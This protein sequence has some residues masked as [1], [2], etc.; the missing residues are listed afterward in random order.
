MGLSI[1]TL[2]NG[3]VNVLDEDLDSEPAEGRV[4]GVTETDRYSNGD[5]IEFDG[6]SRTEMIDKL[7]AEFGMDDK[8][9]AVSKSPQQVNKSIRK[10]VKKR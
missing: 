5:I 8:L 1:R 3:W 10:Q 6:Q 4:D 7:L 9:I 2:D